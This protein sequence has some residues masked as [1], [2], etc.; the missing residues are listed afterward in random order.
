MDTYSE[1]PT[2]PYPLHDA[3]LVER[4]HGEEDFGRVCEAELL[5]IR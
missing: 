4:Q 5:V 1:F 3:E 2:P